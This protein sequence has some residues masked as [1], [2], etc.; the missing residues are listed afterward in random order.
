[1]RVFEEDDDSR[2]P[3]F[4]PHDSD[5]LRRYF[6]A[7]GYVVVRGL[8]PAASCDAA[9]ASFASELRPFRGHIYRQ[10]TAAAERHVLSPQGYVLN[11]ILNL[12]DLSTRFFPEFKRAALEVLTEPA[13]QAIARNLTGVGA[14]V[15]QSMY[16]D[17]NPNTQA[18][19][20]CYYIDSSRQGALLSAW[21]ALEDI[22]V[23]AGRFFVYPGSHRLLL[24]RNSGSLNLA[25]SDQ[26]YH[27]RILDEVRANGLECH[28]PALRKG[29]VLFWAA[30]TIHG[31][32]KTLEPQCS[33]SSI[34]M[35]IIPADT[36]LVHFQALT[37]RL[38]VR[39][40]NGASVHHP[41]DQDR[42]RY[43]AL[44]WAES[45]FPTPFRLVKRLAI[46][47]LTR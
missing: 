46:R 32:L 16:F 24:P 25:F 5:A 44:L 38:R 10:T 37:R 11:P 47:M 28:A 15:V 39:Q 4:S 7:Q 45:W 41:K 26:G 8:V 2:D 34:T 17:G 22:A 23:G 14:V 9:R 36:Q 19:Q 3:S 21:I 12:Q 30:C 43:R 27:P 29:D 18:H 31:S 35:Q 40:I 6:E 33:R 13:V 20:D 1:M 42:L